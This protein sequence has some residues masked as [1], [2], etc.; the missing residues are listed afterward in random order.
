MVQKIF[1][2]SLSLSLSFNKI[3]EWIKEGNALI[4]LIQL[5]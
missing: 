1:S 2:A 3:D 4:I 5:L